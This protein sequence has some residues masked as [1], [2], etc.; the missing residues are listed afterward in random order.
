M[1]GR[2]G[3]V[4]REALTLPAANVI[5][6]IIVNNNNNNNNNKALFHHTS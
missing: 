1:K 5:D 4:R 2:F 6:N 3:R